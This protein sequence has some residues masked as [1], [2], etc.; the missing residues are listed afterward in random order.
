MAANRATAQAAQL[1]GTKGAKG[2]KRRLLVA[3]MRGSQKSG[4][5]ILVLEAGLTHS[6]SVAIS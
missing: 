2:L 4:R 1:D 3:Q 6:Y 5:K